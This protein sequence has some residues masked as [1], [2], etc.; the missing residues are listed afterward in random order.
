M[1]VKKGLERV[2]K[3]GGRV[4]SRSN[5]KKVRGKVVQKP[6][7]GCGV[8]E[9]HEKASPSRVDETTLYVIGDTGES[10]ISEGDK[11]CKRRPVVEFGFWCD[12]GS[13]CEHE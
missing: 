8:G 6:R 11:G 5:S 2:L 7:A 10:V 4:K 1:L 13:E 3:G 12:R 9:L